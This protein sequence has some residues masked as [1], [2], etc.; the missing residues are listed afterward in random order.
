MRLGKQKGFLGPIGDDLPSLIPL[1]TALILFFGAYG[2]IYR[3]FNEKNADIEFK[4]NTNVLANRLRETSYFSTPG[5]FEA[6]C[7]VERQEAGVQFHAGILRL[8]NKLNPQTP[9]YDMANCPTGAD[10][11]TVSSDCPLVELRPADL[12]KLKDQFLSGPADPSDSTA[13]IKKFEC[14]SMGPPNDPQ[15]ATLDVSNPNDPKQ[16]PNIGPG[17]QYIF[18]FFPVA[19]EVADP[20]TNKFYVQPSQLVVVTWK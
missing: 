6:I 14:C 4:L 16:W 5:D 3:G 13:G 9:V 15:C 8:P 12:V 11:C 1:V 17:Q 10:C 20:A 19:V 7:N 18:R 2:V